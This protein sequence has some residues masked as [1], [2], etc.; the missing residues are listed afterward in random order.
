MRRGGKNRKGPGRPPL[1]QTERVYNAVARGAQD[2]AEI[3]RRARVEKT[4]VHP[5][6]NRLRARGLIR[7]FTGTLR[8]VKAFKDYRPGGK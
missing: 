6:L 1:T 5:L 8:T 3:S 7:G 4:N 2:A